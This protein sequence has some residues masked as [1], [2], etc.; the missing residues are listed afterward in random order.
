MKTYTRG[1]VPLHAVSHSGIY[2][3]VYASDC[4]LTK[5]IS[6][7]LQGAALSSTERFHR[8]YP[9]VKRGMITQP[10]KV[11]NDTRRLQKRRGHLALV[12]D[13]KR[14]RGWETRLTAL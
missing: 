1:G 8:P 4:Q 9:S 5:E 2:F 7:T 6:S 11:G 13:P 14:K 3:N 10:P 12:I